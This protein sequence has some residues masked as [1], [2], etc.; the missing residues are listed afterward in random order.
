MFLSKETIAEVAILCRAGDHGAKDALMCYCAGRIAGCDRD[1]LVAMFRRYAADVQELARAHG[2]ERQAI[3]A[4]MEDCALQ[5]AHGDVPS[6]LRIRQLLFK[7]AIEN[8]HA[9]F[10]TIQNAPHL[11]IGGPGNGPPDNKLRVNL[12]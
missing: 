7:M 8:T 6:I 11:A 2:L 3:N 1:E 12:A 5:A 4:D 9:L 10:L